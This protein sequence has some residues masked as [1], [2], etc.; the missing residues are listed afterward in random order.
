MTMFSHKEIDMA[1]MYKA[2]FCALGALLLALGAI[3]AIATASPAR[4]G[5]PAVLPMPVLA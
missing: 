1:R 2:T 4:A 5:S 3:G